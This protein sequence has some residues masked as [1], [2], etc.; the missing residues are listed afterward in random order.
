MGL[1]E[2][3]KTPKKKANVLSKWAKFLD[4]GRVRSPFLPFGDRDFSGGWD[5]CASSCIE[6]CDTQPERA[7]A[8]WPPCHQVT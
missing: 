3:F 2:G 1:L 6:S 8:S 4:R 7:S 5:G